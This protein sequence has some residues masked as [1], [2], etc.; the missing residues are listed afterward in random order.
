MNIVLYGEAV[1]NKGYEYFRDCVYDAELQ[2][3]A[4]DLESYGLHTFYEME[5]AVERAMQVCRTL[6][7]PVRAH[8]KVIYISQDHQL[9][10]DWRLSALGRK[11]VLLNANPSNRYIARLQIELMGDR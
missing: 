8:F 9:Y 6:D 2:Y 1:E 4:S 10:C 7:L 3:R 5:A 11:L